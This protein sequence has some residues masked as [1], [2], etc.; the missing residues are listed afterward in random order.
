[1]KLGVFSDIHGNW[2]AFKAVIKAY[3][4]E[5]IDTYICLGDIVGYGADPNKCI[6]KVRG[7]TE[8]VIAGNHDMAAINRTDTKNFNQYAQQAVNWTNAALKDKNKQYLEQ[9]PFT[10]E[11]ENILFV[12]ATP[13]NPEQWNYALSIDQAQFVFETFTQQICC[14]GHSHYPIF[15]RKTAKDIELLP[16][17]KIELRAGE[18]YIMN[19]GSVGQPRDGKPLACYG[20]IDLGQK[21]MEIK[22]TPYNVEK[23]QKKIRKAGLPDYLA[24][25]I[26]KGR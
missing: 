26:G 12:H 6:K 16:A 1:M 23:A 22:R 20:I 8:L 13:Q 19:V 15:F 3:K 7:L 14:I 9:L 21:I 4:A 2:E 5:K 10:L 25:R 24:D 17:G 11:R 18:R